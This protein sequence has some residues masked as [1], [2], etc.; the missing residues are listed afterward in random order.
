MWI[1]DTTF[2]IFFITP[3]VTKKNGVVSNVRHSVHCAEFNMS[4][5][6]CSC[7]NESTDCN[8]LEVAMSLSSFQLQD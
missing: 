5:Q 1:L 6:P 4:A 7:R 2:I 3:K 8:T